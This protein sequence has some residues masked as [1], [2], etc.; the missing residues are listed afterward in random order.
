MIFTTFENI[1]T[2]KLLG[3]SIRKDRENAIIRQ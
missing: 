3:V 1:N 2:E